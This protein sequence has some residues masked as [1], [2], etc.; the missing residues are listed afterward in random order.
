M[1]KKTKKTKLKIKNIFIFIII[2][3]III[4]LILFIPKH[5]EIKKEISK[6][7]TLGYNTTEINKLNKLSKEEL[8]IIEKNEYNKN[9]VDII[10]SKS[11]K[12]N[13]LKLYLKYIGNEVN[14]DVISFINEKYYIN[15]F[16]DRYLS[17][18]E[19]NKD[20]SYKEIVK[21]VNSNLDFKFYDDS[22]EADTSKGMYTLVNKYYYLDKNYVPD[23]LVDVEKEY[24]RDSAK[25]NK[26]AYE[27]FKKMA[28]EAKKEGLTLLITTAY[29]NYNFQA[30]L[31]NN[32]VRQDGKEQA[33]TYSA[34]PGYSEHQLGYSVDLT[35][36]ERVSFGE[37]KNTK[38]FAWLKD[39]AY[40]YGFIIR[41][42]EANQYITG[43][44]PESWHYRYVGNDIAK[45]IYE[46][47]ITY[48]EYYAYFLR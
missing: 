17:Y 48:E 20:L 2:I 34:R 39:N 43:Y 16:L 8:N 27:N 3:C 46:N 22:K 31:Y 21:R 32:Y 14:D 11:Y 1:K 30:T 28:D 29:R 35:N 4:C 26:T 12:K 10:S 42:T 18:K 24:A 41:Y 23:D 33:D 15:D 40:K 37:F 47:N 45:Y 5:K 7:E 38:E 36:K 19:K 9:L 13:N 25:I 44:V 6:L